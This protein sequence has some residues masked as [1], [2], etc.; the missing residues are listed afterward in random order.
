MRAEDGSYAAEGDEDAYDSWAFL[1]ECT[2]PTD[3]G[4]T[5]ET[6]EAFEQAMASAAA[7]TEATPS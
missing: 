2:E 3:L 6:V 4:E 1:M 5:Y 7:S